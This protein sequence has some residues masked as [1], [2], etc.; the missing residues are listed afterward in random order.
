M[1]FGCEATHNIS[2]PS[3]YTEIAGTLQTGTGNRAMRG[4]LKGPIFPV[5]L[6][7]REGALVD[8]ILG[9]LLFDLT[10]TVKR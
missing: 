1:S 6:T 5:D 9:I 3:W 7:G 8:N 4:I 2:S 10:R